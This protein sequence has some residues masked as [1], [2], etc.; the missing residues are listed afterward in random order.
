LERKH[1]NAMLLE[2]SATP[3]AAR[4]FIKALRA[5]S[6]VAIMAGL[7]DDDPTHGVRVKVRKTSGF[8]SWNEEEIAQFEAV[9]PIGT[10]ARLAFGL[11]LY[12]AQRRGDVIRMGR[13]HVRDGFIVV[14]QQKTGA[15]L[16]IPICPELQEVLAAH[17][18]TSMTYL[19]TAAGAPFTANGFTDWFRKMCIKADLP[20][21]L[22]AHGLRKAACRRLAEAGCSANQIAAISGHATLGEVSRYTKAADQ[23]RLA[24]DAMRAMRT[25]CAP[26]VKS[27]AASVKRPSQ[28]V[29]KK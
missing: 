22:S 13:Q 19:T 7:R 21:G 2:K 4:A 6:V 11:L 8:R 5:V 15:V 26:G 25:K 14:R 24:A 10:R 20:L 16:Q 3:H 29:E 17:P 18:V 9:H 23:K 28:P 1:V 27:G 12:T